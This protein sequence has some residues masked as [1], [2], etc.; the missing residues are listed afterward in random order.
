[1]KIKNKFCLALPTNSQNKFT[2]SKIYCNQQGKFELWAKKWNSSFNILTFH[3]NIINF[4]HKPSSEELVFSCCFRLFVSWILLQPGLWHPS[5]LLPCQHVSFCLH[6]VA[7]IGKRGLLE[8]QNL[9][10]WSTE[11]LIMILL[12]IIKFTRT[13]LCSPST[14]YYQY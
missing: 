1:M 9:V 14:C 13:I 8:L 10:W 4:C 11:V 2:F 12:F 7:N 3:F 6:P 5:V